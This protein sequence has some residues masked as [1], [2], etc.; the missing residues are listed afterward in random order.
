MTGNGSPQDESAENNCKSEQSRFAE[1]KVRTINRV[2]AAFKDPWN[3]IGSALA[4]GAAWLLSGSPGVALLGWLIF[5]AIY[6]LV[7]P[8]SSWLTRRLAGRARALL[9]QRQRALE[10]A[11]F[12]LLL[13]GDRERF[14]ELSRLRAEIAAKLPPGGAWVETILGK[15]DDLQ[16]RFL[17][18]ARKRAQFRGTLADLARREDVR[19]LDRAGRPLPPLGRQR[20]LAVANVETLYHWLQ[21]AYARR[22]AETDAEIASAT[23]EQTRALL[24]KS[25]EVVAELRDSAEQLARAALNIERQLDLVCD[26]LALIRGQAQTCPSEQLVGDVEDLVRSS[27]ALSE[28]LVELAPLEQ[29]IRR[30]LP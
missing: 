6:L 2:I 18:F 1:P 14:R 4:A 8:R 10:Q 15:L 12:P 27:R 24:Q 23:N 20:A 29:Q 22:L 5:E 17:E 9:A 13:P 11:Y 26:S 28:A 3:L 7:A 21:E 16:E 30:P 25:R 19:P